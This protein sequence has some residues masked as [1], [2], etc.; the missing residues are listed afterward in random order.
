VTTPKGTAD[1][2]VAGVYYVDDIVTER[3]RFEDGRV[4]VPDGPGLGVEVD[5]EKLAHYAT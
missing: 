4:L 1:G 3:F 5:T 2:A